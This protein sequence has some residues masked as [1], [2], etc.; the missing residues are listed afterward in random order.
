MAR[1]P[2]EV[3]QRRLDPAG[4]LHYPS[5]SP[6]GSALQNLGSSLQ[7]VAE[8]IRQRDDQRDNFT[9]DIKEREFQ[10]RVAGLEDQAVQNAAIDGRGIR[11]SVYG[12]GDQQGSFDTLFDE[13][14]GQIPEGKRQ[15]FI[16]KRQLYKDQGSVRLATQQYGKEQAY[17]KV[18]IAKVQN[19]LVNQIATGDPASFEQ[20]RQQGI[21]LIDKSGLPALEKEV[22]KQNWRAN[23]G[24]ALFASK[25]ARDPSF[26]VNARAA[27]GLAPKVENATVLEAMQH[28]ESGSDPNAVSPKG[29]SGLMQVMPAT[30][31]EIAQELGDTAYPKTEAAQEAYLKRPDVSRRYGEHYF[32][33]M[34]ARYGGDQEAALIAYNG[35]PVRA[36]AWLAAGRDDSVIPKESANYYKKVAA[37]M[38]EAPTV[39]KRSGGEDVPIITRH[40]QG[41]ISAPDIKGVS[42]AAMARFRQLQNAWGSSIPIVSGYRDKQRNKNAG[43]A[44]SSQHIHGSALDLD[45]SNMTVT[46]RKEFIRAASAAG[47]TGIG[48]YKNSIHVDIGPRRSWG[49]SHGSESVPDWA[50]SVIADHLSGKAAPS[51][52]IKDGLYQTDDA[53]AGI[54]FERRLALA[55]Q[56]D[57]QV[58]QASR[59]ASA[60]ASVAYT[61]HK[62][63]I[64]LALA[65]GSIRDEDVI[66]ADRQ[67]NDGDKAVFIRRIREQNKEGIQ[68]QADL[69]AL[70][71][72]N[73]VLD[74][75]EAKDKT[76][77]DKAFAAASQSVQAD[78]RQTLAE[79]IIRQTGIVPDSVVN[80]LRRN[81]SSTDAV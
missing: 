58:N 62:D 19:D 33:K 43:G 35:G 60:Q 17:Y 75:Y 18:E 59:A 32:N 81:L 28:V 71:S 10:A 6:V 34:M 80:D 5:G 65:Q 42:P 12:A 49:P 55:N 73:L 21:D 79:D 69:A 41:R 56:A 20:F 57:V 4:P 9:A 8:R 77:I 51:A 39:Q 22:A 64:D 67:L 46:Q 54:P 31:A 76:R 3:A 29:A 61:A 50:R 15:E 13:Y 45:V 47:F 23:A 38:G 1:I 26:A 2:L 24:E 30:G 36:D 16:A 40:Q 63:A 37:R 70:G 53:Y 27:L 11:D 48:V 44:K 25:L 7:G 68:V 74:A 72:G 14:A 52:S 78:Q 66:A